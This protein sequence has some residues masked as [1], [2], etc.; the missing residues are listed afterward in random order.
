MSSSTGFTG[1]SDNT[2]LQKDTVHQ[3]S[4]GH[5]AKSHNVHIFAVIHE[6]PVTSSILVGNHSVVTK[7]SHSCNIKTHFHSQTGAKPF[8]SDTSGKTV[9]SE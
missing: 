8:Q 3:H 7:F 2:F 1:D 6:K 5:Q 4:I 9:F